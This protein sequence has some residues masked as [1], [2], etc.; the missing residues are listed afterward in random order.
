MSIKIGSVVFT[1]GDTR[2]MQGKER[3]GTKSQTPYISH[4]HR[5]AHCERILSKFCV[6]KDMADVIICAKFGIKMFRG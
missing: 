3:K 6:S 1:V 2:K 4:I 5:E